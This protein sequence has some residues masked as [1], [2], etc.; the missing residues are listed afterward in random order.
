MQ[1]ETRIFATFLFIVTTSVNGVFYKLFVNNC[2]GDSM[3]HLL[4]HLFIA[5]GMSIG[6]S[7]L[8]QKTGVT[9]GFSRNKD[10]KTK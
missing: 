3:F 4:S 10:G 2:E 7:F 8:L 9:I 1:K 5:L 6:F